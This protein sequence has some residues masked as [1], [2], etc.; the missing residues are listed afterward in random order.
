MPGGGI[1]FAETPLQT[2]VR[3]CKEEIGLIVEKA[4]LI[5]NHSIYHECSEG[6]FH[7]IGMIYRIDSYQMLS[8]QF[9]NEPL[10]FSIDELKEKKCSLLLE[11][12]LKEEQ[13][14]SLSQPSNA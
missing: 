12:L 2:L 8:G 7:I 13:I 4:S 14:F 3:E 9:E 6:I 11:S 10:W 1:E 5:T